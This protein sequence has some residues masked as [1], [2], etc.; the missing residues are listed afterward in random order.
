MTLRAISTVV[1]SGALW[2][3][4]SSWAQ[5]LPPLQSEIRAYVV[6]SPRAALMARPMV[7]REDTGG[8]IIG[9]KDG[10]I[11]PVG[12]CLT[13]GAAHNFA[14]D[15]ARILVRP[16][17][18]LDVQ[19][20]PHA[21]GVWYENTEGWL[22]TFLMVERLDP[23]SGEWTV[24]GRDGARDRR[25]G[26]SIGTTDLIHV[27]VEVDQPGDHHLRARMWTF[28]IPNCPSP[29][30]HLRT[31]GDVD[32]TAVDIILRVLDGP[33]TPADMEWA[34]EPEALDRWPLPGL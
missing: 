18:I 28:A 33:P 25:R 24:I 27:P 2:A 17:A 23:E 8:P 5:D 26:P 9:D 34:Q 14:R 16:G 3:G 30:A 13:T 22:G 21:E 32:R 20:A 11:I 15:D 10:T 1:L 4:G 6:A 19:M 29:L 31:C 7:D 12:P